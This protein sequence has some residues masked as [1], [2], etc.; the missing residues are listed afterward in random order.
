MNQSRN[1]TNNKNAAL[2]ANKKPTPK[3]HKKKIFTLKQLLKEHNDYFIKTYLDALLEKSDS[4]MHLFSVEMF[5]YIVI[6]GCFF[7]DYGIYFGLMSGMPALKD[8]I[9]FILNFILSAITILLV[10][11]IKETGDKPTAKSKSY[12]TLAVLIYI[13]IFAM[14]VLAILLFNNNYVHIMIPVILI[15]NLLMTLIFYE[16]ALAKAEKVQLISTIS[17]DLKHKLKKQ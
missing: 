14:S 16:K 4:K 17:K 2:T 7:I 9:F 11:Y 5:N 10:S 8:V 15:I 12:V 1:Q 3:H 6:L 13:L